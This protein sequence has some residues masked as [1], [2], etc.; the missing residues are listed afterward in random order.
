MVSSEPLVVYMVNETSGGPF[1]FNFSLPAIPIFCRLFL[2]SHSPSFLASIFSS[3][4][5]HD[6]SKSAVTHFHRRRLPSSNRS[7]VSFQYGI[8]IYKIILSK[9]F[10]QSY[11]LLIIG[12]GNSV[13]IHYQSI[14]KKKMPQGNVQKTLP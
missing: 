13:I 1:F 14:L 9:Y 2:F 4:R 10:S 5:Q 11:S 12:M 6:S 8:K 7:F 3:V